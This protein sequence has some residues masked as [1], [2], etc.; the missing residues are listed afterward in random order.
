VQAQCPDFATTE[1]KVFD[2]LWEQHI[3]V[4]HS[5]SIFSTAGGKCT[6][7]VTKVPRPT[8]DVDADGYSD[9]YDKVKL[10][11]FSSAER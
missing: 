1:S 4:A 9:G 11:G 5:E 7:N 6:F 10:L 3:S 2:G 8:T